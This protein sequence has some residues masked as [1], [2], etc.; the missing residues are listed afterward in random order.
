[1]PYMRIQMGLQRKTQTPCND[2]LPKLHDKSQDTGRGV[3]NR[4]E[5]RH[6]QSKG[7]QKQDT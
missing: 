7:L 4:Y 6:H 1:M 3:K 5:S 2:K